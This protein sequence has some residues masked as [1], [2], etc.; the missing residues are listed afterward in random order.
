VFPLA[1][2][3]ACQNEPKKDQ[4]I[5]ADRSRPLIWPAADPGPY[6]VGY[7]VMHEYDR[8]RTSNPSATI[9][10]S[11]RRSRSPGR[12]R[13]RSG[14]LRSI[15]RPKPPEARGV[16]SRPGDRTDLRPHRLSG[17]A[18]VMNR[19]KQIWPLEFRVPPRPSRDPGKI[20]SALREEVFAVKDAV[21]EK[22][23]FPLIV[24]LPGYNGSPNGHAYFFEYLAS[25]RLCRRLSPEHGDE[26]TGDRNEAA[27]LEVQARTWSF[28][29]ARMG[30][31]RTWT[32]PG[33]GRRG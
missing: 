13:F 9:S 14:T 22:G 11:G 12:S 21:P 3:A 18:I 7:R 6:D 10:G 5:T 30:T 23:P 20:E 24:H 4:A 28:V 27:S 19:L 15:S 26:P 16:L 29:V 17:W 32:S 8:T 31:F 1:F 2:H 25:P 33:S